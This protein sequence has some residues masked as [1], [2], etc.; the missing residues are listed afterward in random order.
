MIEAPLKDFISKYEKH[1]SKAINARNVRLSIPDGYFSLLKNLAERGLRADILEDVKE[2]IY[3]SLVS[4]MGEENTVRVLKVLV[5]Q[6]K[7]FADQDL[8]FTT[9]NSVTLKISDHI[10]KNELIP[11]VTE[12]NRKTLDSTLSKTRNLQK[13]LG[14]MCKNGLGSHCF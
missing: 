12:V 9:I 10:F 5:K 13:L 2:L 11:E 3:S 8:Y 1:R 7:E 14:C 4:R 6:R